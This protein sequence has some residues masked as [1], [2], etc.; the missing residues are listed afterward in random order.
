MIDHRDCKKSNNRFDNLREATAISNMQNMRRAMKGNL[1]GLLGVRFRDGK[2][3]AQ[4]KI[5]GKSK[6]LGLFKTA[7]EAHAEYVLAKRL[8][9]PSGTL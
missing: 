5:N 3:S 2:Y 6:H 8:H 1:T 4:I 7:E 9:H